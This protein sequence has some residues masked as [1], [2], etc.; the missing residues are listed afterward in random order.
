MDKHQKILFRDSTKMVKLLEKN[1]IRYPH[2]FVFNINYLSIATF[3]EVYMS[4]NKTQI[5]QICIYLA[6]D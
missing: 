5:V 6:S 2:R 3:I 4:S 1:K